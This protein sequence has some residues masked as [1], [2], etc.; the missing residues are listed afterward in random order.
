MTYDSR[1]MF[2]GAPPVIF[3]RAKALREKQT[4]AEKYLWNYLS[5][6]QRKGFRFKSQHPIH[7]F[8]ADFYCHKCKLVV[9]VDGGIH[10]EEQQKERDA[11][12]NYFMK[13][14]GLTVLRFTNDEVMENIEKVLDTID[15][16]LI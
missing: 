14:V 4:E 11:A 2:Y 8:I 5:K 6:N 3:E 1:E 10:Y 16:H 13:E 15:A 7:L 9:E 12:R